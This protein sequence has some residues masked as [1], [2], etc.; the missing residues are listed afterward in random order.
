MTAAPRSI[1]RSIASTSRASFTGFG[2]GSVEEWE[3]EAGILEVGVSV[4]V[5]EENESST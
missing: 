4:Q 5:F 1:S 3:G 2:G